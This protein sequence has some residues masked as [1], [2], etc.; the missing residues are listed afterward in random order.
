MIDI[1]QP[2]APYSMATLAAAPWHG[3]NNVFSDAR[4]RNEAAVSAW[5][6]YVVLR[7]E[8]AQGYLWTQEVGQRDS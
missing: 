7:P 3:V 8:S 2:G 1:G 5:S 4:Q 6:P